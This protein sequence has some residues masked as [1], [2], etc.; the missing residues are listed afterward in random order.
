[1]TRSNLAGI[2]GAA[3]LFAAV[4]AASAQSPVVPSQGADRAGKGSLAL[5]SG[6][7]NQQPVKKETTKV[8]VTEKE[9]S[10]EISG[11]VYLRSADPEPPGEIIIKNIFGWETADDAEDEY[12]YELEV[13]YGLVENHELILEMPWQ[14]GDGRIDGN[15]D[16]TLGWHWR[17]WNEDGMLPAFALRNY[18]RLPSG[19]DSAGVD[20]I[21]RGLATWTVIDNSMRFHLNPYLKSLNGNNYGDEARHFLWG[22]ALGIDYKLTDDLLFITDYIY[23]AGKEEHT[24]DDHR[25]EFGLDWNIDEHQKLGLALEVGLDGDSHG[26][27]LGARVSYMLSFGG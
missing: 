26:A 17:L 13:E 14:I 7:Q 16:L 15:G 11:P 25:A 20:Y 23:G 6:A 5:G 3:A 4:S 18:V 1:M 12:E 21:L 10:W 8:T 9:T 24:R 27:D 22:T 19:V 2:A